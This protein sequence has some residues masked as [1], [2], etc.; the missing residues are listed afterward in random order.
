MNTE[1]LVK[2]ILI[3]AEKTG[4]SYLLTKFMNVKIK[5]DISPLLALNLVAEQFNSNTITKQS[6]P[7]FIF[8]TLLAANAFKLQQTLIIEAHQLS[9]QYLTRTTQNRSLQQ[10]NL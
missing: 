9:Q 1:Y 3:G 5:P 10:I 2:L 6:K 8:G 7:K 4:K